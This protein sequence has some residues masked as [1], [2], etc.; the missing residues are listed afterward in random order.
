M[1]ELQNKKR[2]SKAI[3]IIVIIILIL[4]PGIRGYS[5]WHWYEYLLIFI[6][7]ALIIY[8]WIMERPKLVHK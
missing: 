2:Q 7:I 8:R 3:D 4:I 1:N 6:S 5:N